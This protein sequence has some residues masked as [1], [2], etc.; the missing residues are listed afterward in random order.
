VLQADLDSK[1]DAVF[2]TPATLVELT[3]WSDKLLSE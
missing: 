2:A 1:G 3:A